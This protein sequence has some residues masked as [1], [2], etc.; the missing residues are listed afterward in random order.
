MSTELTQQLRLASLP[1][2]PIV[3]VQDQRGAEVAFEHL[4]SDPRASGLMIFL[5]DKSGQESFLRSI[6]DRAKEVKL[7]S[8]LR[9]TLL[10]ASEADA[11]KKAEKWIRDQGFS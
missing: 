7:P 1:V 11:I 5:F 3:L 6:S 9:W 2:Q 8:K 4:S 10:S